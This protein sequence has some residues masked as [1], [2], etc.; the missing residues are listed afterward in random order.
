MPSVFPSDAIRQAFDKLFNQP[1][2]KT[3]LNYNKSKTQS[4][5]NYQ[6]N[7]K[8]INAINSYDYKRLNVKKTFY[9]NSGKNF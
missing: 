1:I 6:L 8:K 5:T 7:N 4:L 9:E 2:K 3:L